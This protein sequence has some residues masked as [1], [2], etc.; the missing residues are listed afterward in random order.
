MTTTLIIIIVVVLLAG[1]AKVLMKGSSSVKEG[2][3]PD[4]GKSVPEKDNKSTSVIKKA[5]SMSSDIGV[6]STD[7]FRP[8]PETEFFASRNDEMKKIFASASARPAIVG[9]S[10]F[11]GVGKTCL[12]TTMI[13]KLNSQFPGKSLFVDMQGENPNPPSAE[14][15]MR[16]IIL[17]FHPTQALPSDNKKLAKLY[18]AALKAHKGILILDDVSNADQVK[19]LVPPSSWMLMFTSTK[20][21]LIPKMTAI[22]LEPLEILDAH[23]LLNKLAPEISPSIKE[24]A[25]ICKG[26]S[27]ALEIIGKLF[28]INSTMAPDYFFKKFSE[29]RKKFGEDEKGNLIDGVRASLSLSYKML[30]DNTATV[31]RKLIVFPGSFSA[32]AVS[33]V[34]E[35]PKNLSLTGLEKF[36]LVQFN[37]NNNRYCLHS[38]VRTFLKPLL[39]PGDRGIAERRLATEFMNVLESAHYHVDKE[40]KEALKGLRLFD[41][42]LENI[43]V[44]MEWSRKFCTQDKEAAQMCSAYTEYAATL[45]SKRLSPS[46]CITWF[47]AALSAASQLED[48]EAE[49]KHLLNLGKQYV[50]LN[51]SKKAI[52][53]LQRALALCKKEEDTEGL[54][55]ALNNLCRICQLNNDYDLAKKYLEQNIEL[56]KAAKDDEDEFKLLVQLTNSCI[57]SQEYNKAVLSGEQ[58][59]ELFEIVKDSPLKITLLYNLGKGYLETGEP[60]LALE[61]LEK[62]LGL[63]QKN[64]KSPFLGELF[65]LSADAVFKTGDIASA[66]KHLEKGIEAMRKAKNQAIEGDLMIQ[67]AEIHLLNKNEDR[68]IDYFEE[69]LN[70]S[71][72]NKDRALEGKAL[73]TWSQ[74]L[75][76][77]GNLDDAITRAQKALK[78]FEELKKPEVRDIREKIKK[79]SGA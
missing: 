79:W 57:Q 44:G 48:K 51:Q 15:I 65:K 36:G 39:T 66:L 78:I 75:G 40:G 55:E 41:L 21:I 61:K 68:A 64:P 26:V 3:P 63:A 4:P 2:A 72:D 77:K 34:C 33:F 35:D 27:L 24:I 8:P 31:L 59:M 37:P 67:L 20:P 60:A 46:E 29:E 73:W 38:Q 58:A 25:P 76:E 43:K 1:L 53:T 7:L 74:A 56:A 54:R 30:P 11:S 28:A 32:N 10:G 17:K 45:I 71:Q 62:G 12:A 5:L 22:N 18:R 70:L 42:E 14:D 13:G 19:P 47:E 50:L 16:R 6:K 69:V 9:I 52:D 49:R 23:T